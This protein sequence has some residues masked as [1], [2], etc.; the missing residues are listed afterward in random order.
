MRKLSFLL[1]LSVVTLAL[2]ASCGSGVSDKALLEALNTLAPEAQALYGVIYGDTLPHGDALDDGYCQISSASPY[3]S[4]SEIRA[5]IDRVFS[6]EYAKILANTAF[7]GVSSDEGAISAKFVERG[8]VLFVN[9]EVTADFGA[10]R[11]F[12]ISGAKV[13]KK[14]PYMAIVLLPHSDGD[15]EVTMQ[16]V[17]GKWMIDS[18]MF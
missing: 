17:N 9:P 6:P 8:G 18:P 15:L 13:L 11:T 3:K 1:I 2:L 7:S 12:D 14:N 4:I 10:A 5:A 16:N